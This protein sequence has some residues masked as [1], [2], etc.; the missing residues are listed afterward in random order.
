MQIAH[1]LYVMGSNLPFHVWFAEE[2]VAFTM[3]NQFN[4]G[5]Q[6]KINSVMGSTA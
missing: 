6:D 3:Y 2:V 5:F 4:D 1:Q